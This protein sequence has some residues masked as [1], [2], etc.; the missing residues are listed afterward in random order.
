[1]DAQEKIS[2]ILPV[3]NGD[4]HLNDAIESVIRQNYNPLEIILV[5]D[6]STD[7]TRKIA[8][9][10]PQVRYFYQE[11][12]G[13]AASR[14]KAIQAA[15]GEWF[16]FIDADDLWPE[17]SLQLQLQ[18]RASHPTAE[19]IMG[20]TQIICATQPN[21]TD[22]DQNAE[23]ADPFLSLLL[24]SA[25]IHK[26]AFEKNGLFDETL[27]FSEDVDWFLRAREND[28]HMTTHKNVTQYY[29]KHDQNMTRAKNSAKRY[30]LLALKMSIDRRRQSDGSVK[31]VPNWLNL[32]SAAGVVAR[33]PKV[34]KM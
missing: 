18:Q 33:A 27:K 5:D 28:I 21:H 16:A 29:R 26:H 6:G 10:F 13:P 24:G 9:Q 14:N 20:F 22:Q 11:N 25:L 2:I 15:T 3:Y 12:S 19:I 17:K 34:V 7:N 4:K 8:K 31:S 32:D 30:F 1:M 23:V